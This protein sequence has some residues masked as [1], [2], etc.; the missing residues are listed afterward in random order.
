MTVLY[1][2]TKTIL[3]RQISLFVTIT[4]KECRRSGYAE[5]LIEVQ[6][7]TGAPL[8]MFSRERLMPRLSFVSR[9]YANLWKGL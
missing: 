2:N 9:L 5:I 1:T 6:L 3:A 8:K 4:N 7:T